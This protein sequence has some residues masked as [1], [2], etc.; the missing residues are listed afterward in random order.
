ME[1]IT[2]TSLTN[3]IT[4]EADAYVFLEDLRWPDGKQVC[5]HCDYHGNANYIRPL[6]GLDRKNNRG[7]PTQRRLWAC[8]ACRKQF[9]VL[10][11][12]IFHGTHI[13]ITTWLHVIFDMVADK[14]G[15]ASREVE[16]KYGLTPKSAWFLTQRIREAMKRDPL[17]GMMRGTIVADETY[18]GGLDKNRHVKDRWGT[19]NP[20]PEAPT[21]IA[22]KRGPMRSPGPAYRKS[23][24]LSL[25]DTQTG[26]VRSKVIPDVTG[27]TLRKAIADQVDMSATEL[28][29][30][31]GRGYV[32]FKDELAAHRTV[33]H[34]EDQYVRFEGQTM[35]TTNSAEGYF[36][37]LKRSIDGTHHHVSAT[38]LPR[39]LAEFDFR[40]S[41]RKLTD[42][43]RMQTLMGQTSGRRLSYRPLTE[44]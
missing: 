26:E 28:H 30:D 42:T 24:V 22:G 18:I 12:T 1:R 16:R 29:T 34:S 13:A 7:K 15:V 41:T 11:G 35:I 3:R 37:Q 25:I 19:Q 36:S 14:N 10:T 40:Y 6:N 23:S 27:H 38:H 43:G 44:R 32:T 39:Y 33:N 31:E 20:G 17:V 2:V 5:P 4:C 9:S 21:R 8:P